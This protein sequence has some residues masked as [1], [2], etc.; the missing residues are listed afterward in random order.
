MKS[1]VIYLG[2]AAIGYLLATPFRKYRERL[3][4]IGALL[5]AVVVTLVFAMGFRIGSNESILSELGTIGLYSVAFSV[6]P[7]ITTVFLL[8]IVRKWMGF[9]HQGAYKGADGAAGEKMETKERSNLSESLPPTE[10]KKNILSNSTIRIAFA[11][12]LGSIIGYT[13][14]VRSEW[15]D[16]EMTYHVSGI[17]ITYALYLMIFLVG[18]DMGLDGT[19]MQRFRKVGM[20]VFIFPLVTGIATVTAVLVCGIFTPLSIKE[21]LGIACTFGWYSLGPSVMMDAGLI[22]AG[23]IAFLANFLRVIISLCTIPFV[24][25]KVGYIE[26]TGMPVAAAMDICI[27][28]IEASANKSVAIYA[29]VSGCSFTV[30]VTTLVPFIVAF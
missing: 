30:M 29:F 17:Y 23:A 9:N 4:W 19:A 3:K 15:L 21:L 6:I 26:V 11:V 24:A 27:A 1:F 20:R 13:A 8:H 2:M 25:K 7:L 5:S 14:V 28:T 18:V 10:K 22:T 16:Y 12:I